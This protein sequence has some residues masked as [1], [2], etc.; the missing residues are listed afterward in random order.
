MAVERYCLSN[1]YLDKSQKNS[2]AYSQ[3]PKD[4]LL[5]S[6]IGYLNSP[7]GKCYPTRLATILS[8]RYYYSQECLEN[9]EFMENF[10]EILTFYF[11]PFFFQ[12]FTGCVG[13]EKKFCDIL[14]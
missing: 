14:K 7:M 4:Q 2:D 1:Q 8:F 12:L 9:S 10:S 11:Q 13:G 6:K 3:Q 5:D